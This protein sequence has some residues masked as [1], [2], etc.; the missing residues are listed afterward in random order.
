M[1]R[2]LVTKRSLRQS[3]DSG[4]LP[5]GSDHTLA[6]RQLDG[7][8][9]ADHS[10]EHSIIVNAFDGVDTEPDYNEII[11]QLEAQVGDVY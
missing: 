7:S 3:G 5:V 9:P 8:L 2:N 4:G 11:A 6:R 10:T 1:D